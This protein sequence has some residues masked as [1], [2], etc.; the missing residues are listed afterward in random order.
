MFCLT[1]DYVVVIL[2]GNASFDR[3]R[4]APERK[5]LFSKRIRL[6]TP[7]SF[8]LVIQSDK[9]ATSHYAQVSLFF[10]KWQNFEW[11]KNYYT[12]RGHGCGK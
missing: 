2:A 9:N 7:D 12:R 3:G 6:K 8:L 5:N 1:L 4:L 10:S 11:D